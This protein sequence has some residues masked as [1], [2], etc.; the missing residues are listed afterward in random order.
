M[1]YAFTLD[2]VVFLA[3]DAGRDAVAGA[4]P[5][6]SADRLRAVQTLRA[7]LGERAAP[8]LETAL[9]QDRARGRVPDGWLLTADAAEQATAAPVAAHRA[10]RLAGR[11]VHDVT[12]SVGA[13][14]HALSGVARRVVGS[15]LDPVRLAMA[16]VNVP[17]VPLV[18]ADALAPPSRDTVLVADPARRTAAGRRTWRPADFAPPLDQLAATVLGDRSTDTDTGCQRRHFADTA[19]HDLV[20]STA[21]GLDPALVPWAAEVELVSLDG[22]VREAALWSAGLATTRRRATVVSSRGAGFAVTDAE[23]DDCPVAPA[24]AWIVDPDGAVVRAGLVRQYGA[25]HGLWRLDEHLAYLSG[26]APPPGVRAFRVLEHGRYSEKTLRT[27]LRRRDVG[28]LE[29]LVRGLDVDPNA[30]RPRLRLAGS[31]EATVVLARLASGPAAYVC[32]AVWDGG[33]DRVSATSDRT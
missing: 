33:G 1:A 26:D 7:R 12:C 30:L 3:S 32:E 19:S 31:Q 8:V 14:L 2:D 18:R 22:R 15:D 5:L 21:P 24:G 10:A 17:G 16:R 27:T 11:D 20:V 6:V 28:R 23:D 13:E 29:I 9:L 25:R 4:A